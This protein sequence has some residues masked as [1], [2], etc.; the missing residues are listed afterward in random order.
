MGMKQVLASQTEAIDD[1]VKSVQ[2][3][4]LNKEKKRFLKFRQSCL[5]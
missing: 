2:A 1:V 5:C 4:H 3:T